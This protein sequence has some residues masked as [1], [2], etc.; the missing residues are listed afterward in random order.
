M[1]DLFIGLAVILG[2]IL[3]VTLLASPIIILFLLGAHP[4]WPNKTREFLKT[5]RKKI[6]IAI[7][8]A[9]ILGNLYCVVTAFK[10]DA[11]DVLAVSALQ[12]SLK[13]FGLFFI[14][15]L[16]VAFF[17]GLIKLVKNYKKIKYDNWHIWGYI[18]LACLFYVV[19]LVGIFNFGDSKSLY[20]FL[21]WFVTIFCISGFIRLYTKTPKSKDLG[22]IGMLGV[23]FNPIAPIHLDKEIWWWVDLVVIVYFV[24]LLIKK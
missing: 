20:T 8:A 19:V 11:L 16:L 10:E 12:T 17:K 1:L 2:V 22:V 23:L 5:H 13:Y 21:R 24:Y 9:I 6:I 14:W 18:T 7:I 3:L 15:I 4:D